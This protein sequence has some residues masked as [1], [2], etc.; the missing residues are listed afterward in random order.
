MIPCIRHDGHYFKFCILRS[1]V[2][3]QFRKSVGL[4]QTF[5]HVTQGRSDKTITSLIM[6]VKLSERT[7]S[8]FLNQ[9]LT[10]NHKCIL[11]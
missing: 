4:C 9:R 5:L 11:V 8:V 3:E 2:F 7:F 10:K 1:I 6:I